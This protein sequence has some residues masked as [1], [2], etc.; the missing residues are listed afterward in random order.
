MTTQTQELQTREKRSVEGP[1]EATTAG[2]LFTPAVDIFETEDAITLLADLP[3][4]APDHVNIDVRDNTLTLTGRVEGATE[5]EEDWLLKEYEV[6]SFYR[7]FRLS[8]AIDQAKI[9]ATV[10]DGVLRLVL[11]K[12]EKSRPRRVEV[13]GA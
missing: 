4:V 5:R 7:Q 12:A 8:D 6:G 1:A 11:P 10:A 2:R 9:D 13:R 3:G